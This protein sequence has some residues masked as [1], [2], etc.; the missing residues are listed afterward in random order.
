MLDHL[1]TRE[2]RVIQLRFGLLDG[3][4]RSL[5]EVGRAFGISRARV[6]AIESKALSKLRRPSSRSDILRDYIQD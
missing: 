1:N 2:K 6:S 4:T 5:E 3:Q